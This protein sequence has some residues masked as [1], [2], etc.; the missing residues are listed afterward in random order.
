VGLVA[1]VVVVEVEVDVGVESVFDAVVEVSEISILSSCSFFLRSMRCFC[2][3]VVE[4]C[5]I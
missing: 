5:A 3:L 4:S 2:F 1:V